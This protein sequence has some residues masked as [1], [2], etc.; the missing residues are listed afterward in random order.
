MC[1]ADCVL[2]RADGKLKAAF[3]FPDA[4]TGTIQRPF[5][6]R[7]YR[8]LFIEMCLRHCET[9]IRDCGGFTYRLSAS[10]WNRVNI[11]CAIIGYIA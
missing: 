4:I 1:L 7:G 11:L 9:E 3:M 10:F 5:A 8:F 6:D 2:L